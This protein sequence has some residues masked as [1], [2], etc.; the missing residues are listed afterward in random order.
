[1]MNAKFRKLSKRVVAYMASFAMLLT[2]FMPAV[3]ATD[4]NIIVVSPEVAE[5]SMRVV[6]G[7]NLTARSENYDTPMSRADF[8]LILAKMMRYDGFAVSPSGYRDVTSSTKNA[9]AIEFC[10]MYGYMT[11]ERGLFRPDDAITYMEAMRALVEITGN[12]IEK[13]ISTDAEYMINASLLKIN[14]GISGSSTAPLSVGAAVKMVYNTLNAKSIKVTAISGNGD[15]K[16]IITGDFMETLLSVEKISGVLTKTRYTGMYSNI[17]T[18]NSNV[19]IDDIPYNSERDWSDYLGC[20]VNVYIDHHGDTEQVIFMCIANNNK[21]IEL[22]SEDIIELDSDYRMTYYADEEKD[23]EEKI[24]FSRDTVVIYNGRSAGTINN[25][26]RN[27]LMLRD[28]TGYAVAGNMRLIDS[29]SDGV[30]EVVVMRAYDIMYVSG[31]DDHKMVVMDDTAAIKLD[32]SNYMESKIF[33]SY[34]SGEPTGF[35]SITSGQVLNV[36]KS[37]DGELVYIVI[38]EENYEDAVIEKMSSEGYTAS[39]STYKVSSYFTNNLANKENTKLRIGWTGTLY[40]DVNGRIVATKAEAE[41]YYGYLTAISTPTGLS[42]DVQ[43]KMFTDTGAEPDFV[44]Y[45]CANKVRVNHQP[46]S[47]EN[48]KAQSVFKANDGSLIDQLIQFS[49]NEQDQITAIITADRSNVISTLDFNPSDSWYNADKE[50]ALNFVG[51]VLIKDAACLLLGNK[52]TYPSDG[53]LW[54]IPTD[55]TNESGFMLTTAVSQFAND[56]NYDIE[57]YNINEDGIAE[58]MVRRTD[59]VLDSFSVDSTFFVADIYTV[60]NDDGEIVNEFK[61]YN[62]TKYTNQVLTL[63]TK[64][65]REQSVLNG[66]QKGDV[67]QYNADAKGIVTSV[68]IIHSYNSAPD[69]FYTQLTTPN[70]YKGTVGDSTYGQM[71]FASATSL[72]ISVDRG[73]TFHTFAKHA[74]SQWIVYDTKTGKASIQSEPMIYGI[75]YG[76][77]N[78]SRAYIFTRYNTAWLCVLYV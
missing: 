77:N 75:K 59:E 21:S 73:L 69:T 67:I 55:I 76:I 1:M 25:F 42:T 43:V 24:H 78:T 45:E 9:P 60:L 39:G 70:N 16:E 38:T 64:Q 47:E 48:L 18:G 62:I 66:V 41:H 58:H 44:V 5:N 31:V 52:F 14:S 49:V 26:T 22:V 27:E 32:L 74:T 68:S 30:C 53:K 17:G 15:Y 19:E 63:V 40:M 61:G 8:A 56:T 29:D 3:Q 37:R 4:E 13:T 71:M 2:I 54:V 11:G 28:A 35:D 50:F 51:N 34:D 33:I 10:V 36:A 12:N 23:D 20:Y 65:T 7:L 57:L 72:G 46:V 6:A